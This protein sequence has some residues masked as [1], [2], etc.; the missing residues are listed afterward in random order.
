MYPPGHVGLT[1]VL[2]APLVGW[3]RLRGRRQAATECLQVALVLSVLPDIDKLL[4]G[5]VHRGVT[6]TL[7]AALVAGVFV[8][9]LFQTASADPLGIGAEHPAVCY[10]IGAAGVV[11]HLVGDII[12]P[13]GIQLLFPGSRT[14]YSLDIVQASSATAN[15]LLFVAGTLALI[16]SY[17]VP[18]R[19]HSPAADDGCTDESARK[20]LLS[21]RR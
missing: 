19:T 9:L 1:A 5:V 4:P 13:M 12:T 17:G 18:V 7:P 10:L 15:G 2:F 3:F 11:C 8:V 21:S 16:C 20:A 6:H 14:V